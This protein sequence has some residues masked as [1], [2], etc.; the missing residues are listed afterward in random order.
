MYQIKGEYPDYSTHSLKNYFYLNADQA[1]NPY[2]WS[3]PSHWE[4]TVGGE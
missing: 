3:A 4:G 1:F 2:T